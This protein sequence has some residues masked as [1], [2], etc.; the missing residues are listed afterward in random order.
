MQPNFTTRPDVSGHFGMAA[1]T[2]WLASQTAMR[3]LEIGGNA[4]DAAV[5]A[6][7]VLQVAEPH[8]NGP[9]GEV[10]IVFHNA[11]SHET[12]V[13]CGQGPAPAAA[14][15]TRFKNLGLSQIPGTGL[16]AA[17]IP[18]AFDAWMV[19]LRDH[20]L[21]T[22]AQVLEPAIFYAA[23]GVP[24]TP[25]MMKS[26][27][28]MQGWFNTAWPENAKIYLADGKPPELGSLLRNKALSGMYQRILDASQKVGS[29]RVQQIETA[30]MA[31]KTGFV[32]ETIHEFSQTTRHLDVTGQENGGLITGDDLAGWSATYE[33]PVTAT[34]CG[35][36]V[37]KTGPWGQGPV[38]LQ[39]LQVIEAMGLADVPVHSVQFYHSL[40]EVMKL[41]YA[42][43]ETY[44]CDPAFQDVPCLLYTSPSPRDLSTSR[45]PSSA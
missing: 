40:I 30:R 11:S 1:S 32:A 25:R 26:L 20:G 4:F 17:A 9:L 24:V 34:F 45:M 2:H 44:Y 7:F 42:D 12:K 5:A 22:L 3:M 14:T 19:L 41:T 35:K 28:K 13:L 10:P 33:H 43:R 15:I 16:L 18:G 27:V 29:D 31:W 8:L 37:C 39:G 23:K 6:G 21:L 38:L 36:T